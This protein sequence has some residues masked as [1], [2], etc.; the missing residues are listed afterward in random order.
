ME[1]GKKAKNVQMP[2][3]KGFFRKNFSI[4]ILILLSGMSIAINYYDKENSEMINV[5]VDKN[6]VKASS[7]NA[8]QKIDI[9]VFN[10]SNKT[11]E[12]KETY[13]PKQKNLVEG[14]YINEVI[15]N[16][17]FLTKNM[18]FMSAYTL[19]IDGENTSIIKLNSEFTGLRSNQT[20]FNGFAQSVSNTIM[21]NFGNIQKVIIQIDG[22]AII[23]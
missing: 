17:N 3:K 11:I 18:K 16:T 1:K 14:D 9:F 10:P 5:E 20:L 12:E 2:K 23:Q 8:Q 22:E 19:R 7:N 4:I 15:N 6:L 21:K 13:I